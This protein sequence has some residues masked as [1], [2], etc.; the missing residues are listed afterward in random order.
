[1]YNKGKTWHPECDAAFNRAPPPPPP[2]VFEPEIDI[3]QLLKPL[4]A[5]PQPP[6]P[7]GPPCYGCKQPID[8]VSMM[9][10]MMWTL[11]EGSS[12]ICEIY[13]VDCC[14]EKKLELSNAVA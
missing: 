2:E 9:M 3:E 14:V 12:P 10:K 5:T 8:D 11:L 1:M 13:C 7:R 6:K 4:E